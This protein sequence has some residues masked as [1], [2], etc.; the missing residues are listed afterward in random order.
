MRAA[1]QKESARQKQHKKGVDGE[2]ARV[3][4]E[5]TRIAIRRKKREE[6]RNAK[7]KA[8]LAATSQ[9]GADASDLQKDQRVAFFDESMSDAAG[10]SEYGKV[11]EKSATGN[12][13]I[14]LDPDEVDESERETMLISRDKLELTPILEPTPKIYFDTSFKQYVTITG[15]RQAVDGIY[16]VRDMG[17]ADESYFTMYGNLDEPTLNEYKANDKVF[18]TVDEDSDAAVGVVLSDAGNN[19]YMV[20]LQ[21]PNIP[22][23]ESILYP[24]NLISPKNNFDNE[25]EF[26]CEIQT[27]QSLE[28]ESAAQL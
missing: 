1:A 5:Q 17:E 3:R 13:V 26:T 2:E 23:S 14:S 15:N 9:G 10:R 4:R 25:W 27:A 21:L 24:Q 28:D 19:A 20:L 6:Q 8:A 16:R 22:N 12:Y 7:R 11:V 18:V